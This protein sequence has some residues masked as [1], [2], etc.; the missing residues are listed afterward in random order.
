MLHG[1]GKRA[2]VGS[3]YGHAEHQRLEDDHAAAFR[4]LRTR[5]RNNDADVPQYGRELA[6]G[7][8]SQHENSARQVPLLHSPPQSFE[9]LSVTHI[10]QAD[11]GFASVH[12]IGKRIK[13]VEHTLIVLNAAYER[14]HDAKAL[15]K[16]AQAVRRGPIQ[17]T[18][19]RIP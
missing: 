1:V 14:E 6:V 5:R 8:S 11:S 2:E 9:V 19:Q 13:E 15:D 18:S 12:E 7:N 3:N 17:R 10:N 4:E 16:L